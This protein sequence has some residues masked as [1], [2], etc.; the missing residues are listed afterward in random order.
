MVL[1]QHNVVTKNTKNKE[2]FYFGANAIVPK[3]TFK[4]HCRNVFSRPGI[5]NI[6]GSS[7]TASKNSSRISM[8]NEPSDESYNWSNIYRGHCLSLRYCCRWYLWESPFVIKVL[9]QMP[10]HKCGFLLLVMCWTPTT[11][12]DQ[13]E[14]TDQNSALPYWFF[15]L[16]AGKYSN[17][18]KYNP[19]QKNQFCCKLEFNCLN[20]CGRGNF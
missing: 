5:K 6:A 11:V 3:M 4:P 1:H 9:L 2:K 7:S 19:H 18:P 10:T 13:A 12:E 17:S 15:T 8:G 20:F 14:I 16:F